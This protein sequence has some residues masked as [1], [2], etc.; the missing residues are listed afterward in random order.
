MRNLENILKVNDEKRLLFIGDSITDV[1]TYI[2]LLESFARING[3]TD[4]EAY[5]NL[6]VS[7]ENT[8]GLTEQGHPFPRP[9]VLHRIDRITEVFHGG[10]AVVMYGENDGYGVGFAKF[11]SG[12]NWLGYYMF[13]GGAN[14]NDRLMQENRRTGYPNNYPIIRT[15][16]KRIK[17]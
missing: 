15:A 13:C 9:C 16:S 1:S 14:S 5:I 10:W 6:G 2:S 8:S 4:F 12:A 7:S 3:R 11:A 17:R